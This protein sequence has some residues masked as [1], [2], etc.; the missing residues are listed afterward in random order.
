VVNAPSVCDG[1]LVVPGSM[2]ADFEDGVAGWSGY[3]GGDPLSVESTQPGADMTDR[4][5]RFK[6]GKADTSGVFH[7]TPCSDVS[8]F[9]GVQFWAKGK[10]GD[11]VRFLAVIPATDPT[12]GVGDCDPNA[13]KC[14]DHP[15]KLFTFGPDWELYQASF[16]ELKQYGW[17]IKASFNSVLNAVLWINDGPVDGFDFSIDQVALYKAATKQ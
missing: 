8:A 12:P 17:G 3:I 6:G 15:G 10:G 14:S 11:M 2:I 5:L 9:D 7:L 1:K 16:A 13:G 4:A